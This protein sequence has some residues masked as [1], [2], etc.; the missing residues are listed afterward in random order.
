MRQLLRPCIKELWAHAGTSFKRGSG[1]YK[2]LS[3]TTV[4]SQ[5]CVVA[6]IVPVYA[7]CRVILS[8]ICARN[9]IADTAILQ[10]SLALRELRVVWEGD[11]LMC[12]N[13][14]SVACLAVASPWRKDSSQQ[15]QHQ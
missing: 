14:T 6:K 11:A 9:V 3:R 8:P 13:Q 7:V 15:A 2:F 10:Y 5:Q 1:C 12:M 4:S